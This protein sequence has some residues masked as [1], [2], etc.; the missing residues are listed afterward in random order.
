[1]N[2]NLYNYFRFWIDLTRKS[3]YCLAQYFK[4]SVPQKYSKLLIV[5]PDQRTTK[6]KTEFRIEYYEKLD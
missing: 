2:K 5:L 4:T 6:S 3:K 1:M